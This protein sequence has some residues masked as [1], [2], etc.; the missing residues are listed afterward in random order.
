MWEYLALFVDV[1]A[2]GLLRAYGRLTQVIPY[3]TQCKLNS[4]PVPAYNLRVVMD[5]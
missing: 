1:D 3:T 5:T 2:F 4:L